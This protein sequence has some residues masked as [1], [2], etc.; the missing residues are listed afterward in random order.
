MEKEET[1]HDINFIKWYSGMDE[2]KIRNAYKRYIQES[3]TQ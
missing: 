3:K 1:I 2:V